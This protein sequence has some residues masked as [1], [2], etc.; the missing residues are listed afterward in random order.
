M[1]IILL[2]WSY[3][4]IHFTRATTY[5]M[6][7]I[8]SLAK[9]TGIMYNAQ[10]KIVKIDCVWSTGYVRGLQSV[11]NGSCFNGMMYISAELNAFSSPMWLILFH[12]NAF[13]Y[14]EITG[15]WSVYIGDFTHE[16]CDTVKL[17]LEQSPIS[18][19]RQT[20]WKSCRLVQARVYHN[21]VQFTSFIE[22]DCGTDIPLLNTPL[23]ESGVLSLPGL[24]QHT[25]DF[26]TVTS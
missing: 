8:F 19:T 16:R 26:I 9:K 1:K 2:S 18:S 4:F 25:R 15:T 6:K 13:Y 3:I 17:P 22:N 5:P 20:W 11:V 14:H 12:G 24:G 23:I 21:S 10:E 7:T